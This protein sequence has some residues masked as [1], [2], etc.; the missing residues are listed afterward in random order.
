MSG[1]VNKLMMKDVRGETCE[2]LCP[3]EEATVHQREN[4]ASLAV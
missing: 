1:R 3:V 4:V 2:F